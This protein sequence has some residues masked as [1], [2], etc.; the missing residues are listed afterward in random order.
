MNLVLTRFEKSDLGMLETWCKSIQSDQFM[1][2]VTP[3]LYTKGG[4]V[5]N[6]LWDWYLINQNNQPMG[7]IWIEK[8]NP[9]SEMAKLG[10]LLGSDELFGKGIGSQSVLLAIKLSYKNLKFRTVQLNVRKSNSRAIS[11]YRKCGFSIIREGKKINEANEEIEFY[12][13]QLNL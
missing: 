7:T 8:S 13:M 2:R 1:S 3:D 4:S 11:C 12:T 5:K 10:I 6:E 9:S